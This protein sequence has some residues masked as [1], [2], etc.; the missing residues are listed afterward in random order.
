MKRILITGGS[1][2]L[3]TALVREWT[4]RAILFPV[5]GRHFDLR[6]A[7][8]VGD[9]VR[10][11]APDCI[12]HAAAYTNVDGAEAQ[13]D[14]AAAV[15]DRG[16]AHVAVAAAA[17]G[18]TLVYVSTDYVFDGAARAPYQE[19]D[20]VGPLGVYGRTKLAG[21][22]HV[23]GVPGHLI[24]RTQGL[25]GREGKSFVRSIREAAAAGRAITVV[26]D[27][28]TGVTYADDLARAIRRAR[29]RRRDGHLPLRECGRRRYGPTSPVRCSTSRAIR[30]SPSRARRPGRSA[31]RLGVRRTP[32]SIRPATPRR[33]A[34]CPRRGATRSAAASA[35]PRS[36]SRPPRVRPFMRRSLPGIPSCRS[37]G[38]TGA[39]PEATRARRRRRPLIASLVGSTRERALRRR[40]A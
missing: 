6:D 13:P 1:G 15:N 2:M 7:A 26:E 12:I 33:P 34:S 3:G 27:I 37:R 9:A 28:V 23:E 30:T 39:L 16:S 38:P 36:P 20:P 17:R 4:G 40:A 22:R 5:S 8:A 24:V 14:E 11:L 25:F 10:R 32:C 19:G 29:R 18:A 21:E 35:T 31:A